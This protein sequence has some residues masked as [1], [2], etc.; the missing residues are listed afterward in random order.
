MDTKMAKTAQVTKRTA[1]RLIRAAYEYEA[2]ASR[3]RDAGHDEI[4][5]A[6]RAA[7]TMLGN[8]GRALMDKFE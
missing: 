1:E 8:S 7:S 2:I 4:A 5:N 6:V 3:L